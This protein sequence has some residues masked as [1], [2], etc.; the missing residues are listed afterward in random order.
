M[1]NILTEIKDNISTLTDDVD[2]L[3]EDAT[4]KLCV[5]ENSGNTVK[6]EL[7]VNDDVYEVASYKED[8]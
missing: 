8:K 6:I 5:Y 3:Q 2:V 1:N 7:K 4:L